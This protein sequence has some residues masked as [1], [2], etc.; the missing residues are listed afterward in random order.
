MFYEVDSTL[1]RGLIASDQALIGAGSASQS[2]GT[3]P[4]PSPGLRPPS[5]SGRGSS[6]GR[7]RLF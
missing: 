6:D 3:Q 4:Q 5:P 7:K 1:S 2:Y